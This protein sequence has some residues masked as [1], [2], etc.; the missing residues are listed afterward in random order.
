MIM[1]TPHLPAALRHARYLF[2]CCGNLC[3]RQAMPVNIFLLQQAT[4]LS[5]YSLLPPAI[6]ADIHH[7]GIA[8]L[9]SHARAAHPQMD[10]LPVLTPAQQNLLERASIAAL[11][12]ASFIVD[13]EEL[14]TLM[15]W[16]DELVTVAARL[17]QR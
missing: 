8:A 3:H 9:L 14:H 7:S 4:L 5:L 13:D 17:V 15:L 2:D 10:T 11:A 6:V 16:T 1:H 12:Q